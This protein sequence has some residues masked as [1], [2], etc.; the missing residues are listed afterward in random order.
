MFL[1]PGIG[2]YAY[3]AIGGGGSVPNFAGAIAVVIIFAV[4]VVA[5][6][7]I[8]DILY[9]VLDPRVDWR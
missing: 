2:Q 5:A 6:N 1:W 4:A 3:S 9:G 8:A 7:L